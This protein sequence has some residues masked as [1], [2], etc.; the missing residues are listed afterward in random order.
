MPTLVA[1]RWRPRARRLEAELVG[2]LP[3][4]E[5]HHAVRTDLQLDLRH[6]G[7]A[8]DAR[9]DADET[10][11]RGRPDDGFCS[12]GSSS[13]RSAMNRARSAPSTTARRPRPRSWRACRRRPRRRTVSSLTWSR[14]AARRFAVASWRGG[15]VVSAD[16]APY[17]TRRCANSGQREGASS[18]SSSVATSPTSTSS[19]A[20]S[21]EVV[22]SPG[23]RPRG[24]PRAR[25]TGR[26]R[27]A[28]GAR[29]VRRRT[30][31][32]AV[33]RTRRA[34]PPRRR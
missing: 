22:A 16:N 13:A 11:A 23:R 3:A 33:R 30:P 31:P 4:H 29:V 26:G 9:H 17:L 27:T 7:V 5:R 15:Y 18:R 19:G 20:C 21:A 14:A 6:D 8:H 1:S 28:P 24:S 2:G 10:V 12:A 34:G 32:R 25:A